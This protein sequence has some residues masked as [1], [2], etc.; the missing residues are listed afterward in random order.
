MRIAGISLVA[1]FLLLVGS[2]MFAQAVP[3]DLLAHGDADSFWIA[4]V[5]P[6]SDTADSF[7]QTSLVF[8]Q[9]GEESGWQDLDP[10]P[11]RAVGL[12]GFNDQLVVV[13]DSGKWWL[14][15]P[16]DQKQGAAVPDLGRLIAAANDRDILWGLVVTQYAAPATMAG[17]DLHVGP[18]PAGGA[19]DAPNNPVAAATQPAAPATQLSALAATQSAID[20][21]Q[22]SL[23]PAPERLIAYRFKDGNWV[24]PVQLPGVV[25]HVPEKLSLAV[26]NQL[27]VVAWQRSDGSVEVSR[28]SAAGSWEK[29]IDVPGSGELGDFKL[30]NIQGRIALWVSAPAASHQPQHQAQISSTNPAAGLTVAPLATTAPGTSLASAGWLYTGEDLSLVKEM[31]FTGLNSPPDGPQTVTIAL[32]RIRWIAIADKKRFEQAFDFNGDPIQAVSSVSQ[33]PSEAISIPDAMIAAIGIV[34]A[35]AVAGYLRRGRALQ[36]SQK[37]SPAE[38]FASGTSRSNKTST[39]KSSGSNAVAEAD[40]VV[41]AKKSSPAGQR[42]RARKFPVSGEFP[43]A[44]DSPDKLELAPLGVRFAAGLVDLF[45]IWLT[46]FFLQPLAAK[47]AL[48]DNLTVEKLVALAMLASLFHPMVSEMLCGQSLGKMIFGL[49]VVGSDGNAATLQGLFVRNLLRVFDVALVAPLLLIIASPLRQRLG[50]MAGSTVVIASDL[51][52]ESEKQE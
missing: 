30:L 36:I 8:R 29:P 6:S 52:P 42:A 23:V 35:A 3:R 27:P 18:P 49:R 32:G 13:L 45:P 17:T 43:P 14:V 10:I 15:D 40:P 1:L 4:S 51:P 34:G 44:E 33:V 47:N 16:D 24:N 22:P 28:L 2:A 37:D 50:D 41:D 26:E 11:S 31:K 7:D 5:G 19:P 21:T 9:F 25:P 39:E 12:A 48:G 38:E 46:I 20:A